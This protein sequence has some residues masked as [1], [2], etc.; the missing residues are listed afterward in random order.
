MARSAG[1]A[2]FILRAASPIA[3]SKQAD[4]PAANSCSGLVPMRADPGTESL[5][6]R[7]PSEL[8]EVPF[9]RPPVV[10]VLAVYTTFPAWGV[11][12]AF[13]GC[14]IVYSSFPVYPCASDIKFRR[15]RRQLRRRPAELPEADCARRRP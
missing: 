1:R 7:R 11:V 14:I 2:I 3:L 12:D 6:S 13:C 15:R 8:R 10:W 9:S 4:Q 5:T